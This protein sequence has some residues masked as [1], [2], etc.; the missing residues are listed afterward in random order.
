MEPRF[1]GQPENGLWVVGLVAS[2]GG[3]DALGEVL[4]SLPA[5]FL[6]AVVALQH[7]RP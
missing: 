2:V 4:A 1:S 5:G 3:L 6:A 7:I